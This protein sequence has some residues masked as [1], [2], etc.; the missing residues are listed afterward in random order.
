M[1]GCFGETKMEKMSPCSTTL[2]CSITATRLQISLT[3]AISWVIST[4]VMPSVSF[5]CFRRYRMD[6]VVCGSNADV[7]SSHS[8]TLGSLANA[9]RNGNALLL[10]AGQLAGIGVR[11]IANPHKLQQMCDLVRRFFPAQT[12]AAHGVGYI[13]GDG[14]GR[15]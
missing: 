7:A 4:I 15:H 3:T 11:L 5:K 6:R 8:S 10:P 13:S 2:P 9:S 14:A 12:A 1:T